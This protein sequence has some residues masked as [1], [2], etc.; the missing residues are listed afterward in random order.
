MSV[1][2][3]VA[4]DGTDFH[5]Y[6]RQPAPSADADEIRTVQGVLEGALARLYKQQ[7]R[8]RAASRTD[9]GVHAAGQLVAFDAPFAI[10]LDGLV[11]GLSA[12]LPRDTVVTRAWEEDGEDGAPVEPRHGN[13]GKHYRYRIRCA[14][15]RDPSTRR[16]EW[17]LAKALDVEAMDQAG[18]AFV[19]THD[20]AG[21]RA[22]DCQARTTVRTLE[23]VRIEALKK[24]D[25]GPPGFPGQ[26]MGGGG[27][28]WPGHPGGADVVLAHVS[29]QAFLKNMVRIM[30]GTLVEVGLGKRGVDTI[31]ELLEKPDRRRSGVTAPA[32]GLTLVEVRWPT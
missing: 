17:H 15:L 22:S 27:G 24:I 5:G 1:L 28:S 20:F 16:I 18:Q 13:R 19:G 6:A 10:P 21:F 9:A 11:R 2:L 7:V 12:Q 14:A 3:R 26:R 25:V 31:G 8:T 4:Y 23:S 32:Q 30:V 29:G